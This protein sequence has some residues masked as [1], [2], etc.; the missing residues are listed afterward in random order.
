MNL[1]HYSNNKFNVFEIKKEYQKTSDEGLQEG[2]GIYFADNKE[3]FNSYGS[4][5]YVVDVQ[6]VYNFT[7]ISSIYKIVDVFLKKYD[8]NRI[9]LRLFK[10]NNLVKDYIT[11]I[12]TGHYSITNLIK[13]I[14]LCLEEDIYNLN[15]NFDL[16][17]YE[18]FLLEDWESFLKLK[19]IK[20][21]DRNFKC[22]VY[23]SKNTDLI[24]IIKC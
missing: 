3:V 6:E 18:G 23:I 17:D 5:C 19:V 7:T 10:N 12:K 13:N 21:Y 14:W 8:T 1:Y 16:Y 4:F 9:L 24:K 20:Y 2:Q 15:V 11:G 22:N